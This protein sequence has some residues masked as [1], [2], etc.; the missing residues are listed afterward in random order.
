MA[1]ITDMY[2]Y[3]QQLIPSQWPYSSTLTVQTS[4]LFNNFHQT[5]APKYKT[6]HFPIIKC[7][8]NANIADCPEQYV[9]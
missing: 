2:L 7:T 8:K 3:T 5:L 4:I 1:H 6:I 9:D